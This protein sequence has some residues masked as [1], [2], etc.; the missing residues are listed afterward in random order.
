MDLKSEQSVSLASFIDHTLLKPEATSADIVR[1][2]D[3][4]QAYGFAAVCVN[5]VWVSQAAR[6][7]AGR[8]TAVC[9]V[10]GFPLGATTTEAKVFE[11]RQALENGAK[12]IDM[13]LAIGKLKEGDFSFVEA[14][15]RAVTEVAHQHHALC[16]VIIEA[17][18]LDDTEKL[19]ACQ[20]I[21][22]ANADFVKTSTGFSQGGA[23]IG[24]V[25]LLRQ[26][27]G[28][29]IGVKASG[30]IRSREAAQQLIAA[31]ATRIGTS[32]GVSLIKS[33]DG[34]SKY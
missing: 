13:V 31:G 29:A 18:L 21:Q 22:A 1:C 34:L 15:I 24:D 16:K 4:A 9:T 5:P 19:K 27:V 11:A 8:A 23:T 28:P 25:R 30:G 32:N 17:A 14:D 3:E 20:L 33:E 7:L 6:A 12:E 2:C 26:A 10:V